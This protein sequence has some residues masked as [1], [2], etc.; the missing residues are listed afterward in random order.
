M[1]KMFGRKFFGKI[2]SETWNF[3]LLYFTFGEKDWRIHFYPR[4]GERESWG[5]FLI[6]ILILGFSL[7]AEKAYK[8]FCP[9]CPK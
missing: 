8:N 1:G 2:E 7:S 9:I 3:T 6:F 4:N 5:Y